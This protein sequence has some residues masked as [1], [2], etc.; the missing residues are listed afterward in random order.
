MKFFT[1][2]FAQFEKTPYPRKRAHLASVAQLV[3]A[4]DC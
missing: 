4:P 2:K 3:R 1:K